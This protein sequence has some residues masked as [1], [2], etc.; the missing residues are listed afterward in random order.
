[1]GR[2]ISPPV[3]ATPAWVF[4]G[5]PHAVADETRWIRQSSYCSQA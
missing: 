3:S 2:M 1:M 4:T 5:R